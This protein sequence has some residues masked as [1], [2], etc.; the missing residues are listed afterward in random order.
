MN[1]MIA[2]TILE[3]LGGRKAQVMIG[4][5]DM[6]AHPDGLSFGWKC[7]GARNGANKCWV[8]LDPS[9]TYTVK[10]Y[11]TRAGKVVE[12]GEFDD[13]YNDM[14]VDVFES[15]TGLSLRL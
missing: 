12:K 2:K 13:V 10:F 14:L 6:V 5:R 7:R 3:Q 15:A 11:S 1:N 9:D 8:T 4:M